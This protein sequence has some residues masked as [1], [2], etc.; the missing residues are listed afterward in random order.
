MG[1]PLFD[2]TKQVWEAYEHAPAPR[3]RSEA[4]K[5]ARIYEKLDDGSAVW[6]GEWLFDFP[7]YRNLSAEDLSDWENWV[8]NSG[9][10][11]FLDEIIELCG[12]YARNSENAAGYFLTTGTEIQRK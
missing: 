5:F 2:P 8:N 1:A 11:H 4:A 10:E 6:R 7:K 3:N 9:A 12:R